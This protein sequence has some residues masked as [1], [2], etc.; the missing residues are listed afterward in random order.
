M[1]PA[2]KLNIS[3]AIFFTACAYAVAVAAV[4]VKKSEDLFSALTPAVHNLL[5]R[6]LFDPLSL[7]LTVLIANKLTFTFAVIGIAAFLLASLFI[8]NKALNAISSI[9]FRIIGLY[10]SFV[11]ALLV[12]HVYF[13]AICVSHVFVH[14]S[15]LIIATRLAAARFSRN[16]PPCEK[17]IASLFGVSFA[18]SAI[19][20][21]SAG[22]AYKMTAE[23]CIV[24]ALMIIYDAIYMKKSRNSATFGSVGSPAGMAF[25]LFVSSMSAIG[26]FW[27][28]EPDCNEHQIETGGARIAVKS[29]FRPY[30][31]LLNPAGT[32]MYIV[33][34]EGS[35]S[36]YD[37]R[38]N[39][40]VSSVNANNKGSTQRL[41]YNPA[42][43]QIYSTIW[44]A[45][46][47][48]A[49][50][51]MNL[52]PMRVER[53]IKINKCPAI[54]LELDP[55][56]SSL[57]VLCEAG[58]KL[59]WYD[60]NTWRL[61]GELSFP[62]LTWPHAVKIDQARRRV[63]VCSGSMSR[64][65]YEI[66]ADAKKIIRRAPIGYVN[67]GMAIDPAAR[68]LYISKPIRSGIIA[69]DT[70][71]MKISGFIKARPGVRDVEIDIPGKRLFA[72]NYISGTFQILSL[73]DG[74]ILRETFVG[75]QIRGV[76][77]HDDSN[78]N[79]A[80]SACGV[81]ELKQ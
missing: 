1:E 10:L 58:D 53:T 79:F 34:K 64:Y 40:L 68:K 65:L 36:E 2:K 4:S 70:S 61:K 21:L 71:T 25:I 48:A 12:L 56:T 7:M 32:R 5:G 60:Y 28:S 47:N 66:D 16:D 41:I 74:G 43:D 9:A 35:V 80:A 63:Y 45:K 15:L 73:P 75:K 44:R 62:K 13:T 77:H 20:A 38:A 17:T 3:T 39:A 8:I 27:I 11:S 19:I 23:F 14:V 30:D 59:L 51:V 55:A 22:V 46:D 31:M 24:V 49:V 18:F 33:Y 67:L 76:Y 50:L 72:G 81:M 29:E 78:R 57:L 42:N 54:W 37:L 26:F 52:N 6:T 69:V